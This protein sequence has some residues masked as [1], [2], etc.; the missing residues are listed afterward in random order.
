MRNGSTGKETNGSSAPHRG[1]GPR[2]RKAATP[3]QVKAILA[4]ARRQN[5]DLAG[6]LQQKFGV[7]HPEDPTIRQA[8][9]LIDLLKG[10]A[11]G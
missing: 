6:V 1:D 8:S 5:A 10:A 4:I 2:V 7:E 9:D 3:S 11:E